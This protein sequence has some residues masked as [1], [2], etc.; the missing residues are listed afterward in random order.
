[1][2]CYNIYLILVVFKFYLKSTSDI[3]NLL[4]F[5]KYFY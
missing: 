2:H 5:L 3:Y 4:G 1:M